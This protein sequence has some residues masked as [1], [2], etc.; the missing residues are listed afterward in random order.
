[1]TVGLHGRNG[2]WAVA[3][4]CV[5][6][7]SR[8]EF[9]W[10]KMDLKAEATGGGEVAERDRM[11]PRL[12]EIPNRVENPSISTRNLSSDCYPRI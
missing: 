5:G 4:C 10:V 8:R 1:M 12:I 3:V 7:V 2:E 6:P 9:G 11:A